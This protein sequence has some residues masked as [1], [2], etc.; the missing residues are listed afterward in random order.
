MIVKKNQEIL[1]DL[2]PADCLDIF[3]DYS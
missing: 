1:S 3:G 2:S